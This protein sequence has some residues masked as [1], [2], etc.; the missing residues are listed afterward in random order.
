[1]PEISDKCLIYDSSLISDLLFEGVCVTTV[2]LAPG[3]CVRGV[4]AAVA[5]TGSGESPE[6]GESAGSPGVF[7]N[8]CF[9]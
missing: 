6:S 1:M 8:R 3:A 2:I 9:C 7:Q 4:G 5:A